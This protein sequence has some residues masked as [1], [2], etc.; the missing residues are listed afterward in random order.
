MAS[1]PC[2]VL[3]QHI[4]VTY[5]IYPGT[6]SLIFIM[7]RHPLATQKNTSPSARAHEPEIRYEVLLTDLFN[8]ATGTCQASYYNAGPRASYYND[9]QGKNWQQG[10]MYPQNMH[11][12]Q[13]NPFRLANPHVINQLT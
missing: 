11:H 9:V 2:V 6:E 8:N 10:C 12:K 7:P 13:D 4:H 3:L 1:V 5:H